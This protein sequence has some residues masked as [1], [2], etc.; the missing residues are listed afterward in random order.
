MTDI[1]INTGPNSFRES[2]LVQGFAV[3]PE[4]SDTD[5]ARFAGDLLQHGS[6]LEIPLDREFAERGI[7][8]HV[9]GLYRPEVP[10]FVALK[11]RT[12]SR[13]GGRTGIL[14]G[15]M[16]ARR[17]LASE[18]RFA[19]IRLIHRKAEER[20]EHPL[21]IKHPETGLMSVLFRQGDPKDMEIAPSRVKLRRGLTNYLR[22]TLDEALATCSREAVRHRWHC[23]DILVLDNLRVLHSREPYSGKREL[24]RVLVF[25]GL[26]AG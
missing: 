18:P 23:G 11:C 19:E 16:L 26:D 12:P 1:S 21:F 10:R 6:V 7:P 2:L 3:F 24:Q 14:D 9:E 13:V 4:A 22:N 20:G 17:L 15:N 5:L 8:W 25:R